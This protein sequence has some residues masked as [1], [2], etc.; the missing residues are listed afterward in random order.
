MAADPDDKLLAI[1][2]R[3]VHPHTSDQEVLASKAGYLRVDPERAYISRLRKQKEEEKKNKDKKPLP[4]WH[5]T[6][7]WQAMVTERDEK[8]DELEQTV[9]EQTR[10]IARLERNLQAAEIKAKLAKAQMPRSARTR[11]FAGL[12]SELLG[13]IGE[14]LFGNGWQLDLAKSLG[15]SDRTIRRWVTGA[16]AIPPELVSHLMTVAYARAAEITEVAKHLAQD[17]RPVRI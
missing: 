9:K 14:T 3:I 13:E 8:I 17:H 5:P 6:S 10:Q 11:P 15:V 1:L 2:E 4:D 16:S 12:T 7:K